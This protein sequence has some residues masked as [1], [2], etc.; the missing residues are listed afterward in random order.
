MHG[1]DH[2]GFE[3]VLDPDRLP[4]TGHGGGS[5]GGGG[6]G[7]WLVGLVVVARGAVRRV[8]VRA[9]D[10]GADQPLVHDLGDGLRAVLGYRG[11]RLR[12]RVERLGAVVEGSGGAEGGPLE[13]RGRWIG[14]AEPA[15]VVLMRDGEEG[16]AEER[17]FP[18]EWGSGG[19][20]GTAFTVRVPL[21]GLAAGPPAPHRAPREVEAEAGAR[22]RARLLLADGT[23]AP[24]PAA[25]DLPPPACADAAGNLVVDLGGLPV[26]DRVE[27]RRTGRCG[28]RG[29][30][31]WG[32]RVR[33]RTHRLPLRSRGRRPARAHAPSASR[34]PGRDG[35]GH[36]GH[37]RRPRT[38]RFSARIAPPP[39]K[40]D[41]GLHLDGQP[42]RV[43]TS[44]R[45]APPRRRLRLALERRTAT[46]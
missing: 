31:P 4:V 8:A 32:P 44:R 46:G 42:V 9:L 13:L 14:G 7:G 18:V 30:T 3:M 6:G 33:E 11:G 10:A 43:L 39:P 23:R 38:G 21:D 22:W 45:R 25:P 27:R 15:A 5:G 41:W 36:R 26:V 1:Y 37:R 20:R 35:P 19:D 40:A 16:R 12:V 17:S 34:D 24:L 29:R 2:A 28:S